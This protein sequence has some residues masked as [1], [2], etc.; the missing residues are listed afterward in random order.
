MFLYNHLHFVLPE[1]NETNKPKVIKKKTKNI[2]REKRMNQMLCIKC[3]ALGQCAT[4]ILNDEVFLTI[5][6]KKEQKKNF[7]FY[8]HTKIDKHFSFGITVSM[9]HLKCTLH[10]ALSN[11]I[12]DFYLQWS[13]TSKSKIK[14]IS[15]NQRQMQNKP[16][17][18]KKNQ[19]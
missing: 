2:W 19:K 4:K 10:F 13:C 8:H 14:T 7:R 1:T 12:I 3:V 6:Q 11:V 5:P 16:V 15:L 17:Q 9:M 18:R